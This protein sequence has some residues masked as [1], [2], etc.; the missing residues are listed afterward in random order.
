MMQGDRGL[1][2]DTSGQA[3]ANSCPHLRTLARARS[4]GFDRTFD[5]AYSIC[6]ATWNRAPKE[7]R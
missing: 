6:G 7:T 3:R 2:H 5:E 1:P 4:R